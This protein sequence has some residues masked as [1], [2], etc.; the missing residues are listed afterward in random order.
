MDKIS[1]GLVHYVY[2]CRS[3]TYQNVW[4]DNKK[5]TFACHYFIYIPRSIKCSKMNIHFLHLM[6][7]HFILS[8]YLSR[9]FNGAT[10]KEKKLFELRMPLLEFDRSFSI[11]STHPNYSVNFVKVLLFLP[12]IFN[13]LLQILCVSLDALLVVI[14]YS[15]EI[16]FYYSLFEYIFLD[17]DY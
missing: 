1:A 17:T 5:R 6:I 16:F 7:Q 12:N 9:N 13:L 11:L 10:L 14:N 2:V 3:A 15:L 4:S 8:N